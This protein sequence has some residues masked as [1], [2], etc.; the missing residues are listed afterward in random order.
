MDPTATLG[1]EGVTVTVMGPVLFPLPPHPDKATSAV[2]A[3]AI[4]GKN[5]YFVRISVLRFK[6]VFLV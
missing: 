3:S 6:I 5:L 2:R 1:F 4:A